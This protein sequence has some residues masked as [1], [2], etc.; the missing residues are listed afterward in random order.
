MPKE[1]VGMMI[2]MQG[3]PRGMKEKEEDGAEA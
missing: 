1:D 2:N 3:W